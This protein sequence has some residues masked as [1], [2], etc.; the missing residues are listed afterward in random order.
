MPYVRAAV[1]SSALPLDSFLPIRY[2]C[3]DQQKL[4]INVPKEVPDRD[5]QDHHPYCTVILRG[6][7]RVDISSSGSGSNRDDYSARSRTES[8]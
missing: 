5:S 7:I 8:G 2:M 6:E 1:Y 4:I 3:S